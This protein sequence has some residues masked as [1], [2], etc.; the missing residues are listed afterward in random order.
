MPPPAFDFERMVQA[1]ESVSFADRHTTAASI[2]A[3]SPR[4]PR[5]KPFLIA[6]SEVALLFDSLGSGFGFV[7]RDIASK[8]SILQSHSPLF[9]DLTDA[10]LAEHPIDG[11]TA[12]VPNSAPPATRTLLR[13]MWACRFLDVLMHE[14]AASFAADS[15][16]ESGASE[17]DDGR[18]AVAGNSRTLRDAV[19][20]AYDV[21]LRE[22]HSWGVRR[23]VSAAVYLL[24][25][26]EVFVEKLGVDILR[27]DEYFARVNDSITPL[28]LRMYAF[29]DL[30]DIHD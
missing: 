6:M 10:V 7:R 16:S 15:A 29:Y 19:S 4:L 12:V 13:L 23:A 9:A 25:N 11:S 26:K 30:H 22:H 27:R 5:T 20:R 17:S 14:L 2:P 8:V 21:A 28:V 18:R 24:P 1:F 3:L